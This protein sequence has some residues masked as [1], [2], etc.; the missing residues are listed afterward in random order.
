MTF[1]KGLNI[2]GIMVC[3]LNSVVGMIEFH[4]STT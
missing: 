2:V 3:C 1:F 4:K